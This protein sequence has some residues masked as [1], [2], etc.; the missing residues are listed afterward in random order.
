MEDLIYDF[1]EHEDEC[2]ICYENHNENFKCNRCTI[3]AVPNDLI[4]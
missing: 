1:I 3:Y 4:V 2:Y